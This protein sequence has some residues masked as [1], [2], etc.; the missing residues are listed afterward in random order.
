MNSDIYNV[1]SLANDTEKTV[2]ALHSDAQKVC[3]L[4]YP[5]YDSLYLVVTSRFTFLYSSLCVYGLLKSYTG[6][7]FT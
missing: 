4:G 3:I 6:L 5:S 7:K 1:W 2:E